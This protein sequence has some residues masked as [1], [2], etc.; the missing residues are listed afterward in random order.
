MTLIRIFKTKG[1]AQKAKE[2]LQ[3]GGISSDI[4]EDTF[5]SVPI[6]EFG[7]PARFR[8]EV[9]GNDYFK[10]AAFLAKK[11]RERLKR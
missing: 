7:V 9:G 5:N 3:E 8:L 10:A 2:V 1:E 6:Q 11:L 4:I